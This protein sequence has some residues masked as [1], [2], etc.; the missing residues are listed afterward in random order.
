MSGSQR[1]TQ[2]GVWERLVHYAPKFP[3]FKNQPI[4]T[5]KQEQRQRKAALE[6]MILEILE[7]KCPQC[8][9]SIPP[10]ILSG[11]MKTK[12]RQLECRLS[13]QCKDVKCK[14]IWMIKRRAFNPKS[15]TSVVMNFQ[16]PKHADVQGVGTA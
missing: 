9:S 15:V 13:L 16:T 4:K 2:N 3:E 6:K 11:Y 5:S 8:G 1:D 14:K 10:I 12:E 7:V